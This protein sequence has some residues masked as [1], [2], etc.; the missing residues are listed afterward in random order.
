MAPNVE[1][2]WNHQS[3]LPP[4]NLPLE[5]HDGRSEDGYHHNTQEADCECQLEA[6]PDPRHCKV[7][8]S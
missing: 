1:S 2:E 4:L 8:I 3:P 5:R 7:G 6:F